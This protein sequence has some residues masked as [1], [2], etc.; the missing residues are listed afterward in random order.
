MPV[1]PP[2]NSAAALRSQLYEEGHHD[3]CRQM[4]LKM[5]AGALP[6][7]EH[8]A[9]YALLAWCHFRLHDVDKAHAAATQAVEGATDDQRWA[10]QCLAAVAVKRG[11]D[12]E[13]MRLAEILGDTLN[14]LNLRVARAIVNNDVLELTIPG[15]ARQLAELDTEGAT[16]VQLGN[17]YNNA[18][19]FTLKRS[20]EYDALGFGWMFIAVGYYGDQNWHHRAGAHYRLYCMY[21]EYGLQLH[22]TAAIVTAAQLWDEALQRD[23]DNAT[24]RA[25]RDSCRLDADQ[26]RAIP[27]L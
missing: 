8:R 27:S 1:P 11:D 17:L 7:P 6:D 15:L 2:D 5:L 9:M 10:R 18:A 14:V 20:E 3:E 26:R 12:E 16:S 4:C 19:W 25:K 21:Q 13:F 22:A 24:Y 23:P